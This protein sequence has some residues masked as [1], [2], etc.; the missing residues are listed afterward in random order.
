VR[1]SRCIHSTAD[2]IETEKRFAVALRDMLPSTASTTHLRISFDNGTPILLAFL[3]LS[4]VNQRAPN[5]HIP[6]RSS[7]SGKCYSNLQEDDSFV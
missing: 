2:E 6:F 5:S 4:P 3:P 7:A 1:C